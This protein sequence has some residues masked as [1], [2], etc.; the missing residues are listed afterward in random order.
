MAEV[1]KE[2]GKVY[3][4][5]PGQEGGF[6]EITRSAPIP[7]LNPEQASKAKI[8]VPPLTEQVK[9]FNKNAKG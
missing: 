9:N 6:K 7:L 5:T 4:F 1:Y 8:I 2:N 3:E